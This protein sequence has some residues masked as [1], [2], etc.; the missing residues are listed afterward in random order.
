MK[1]QFIIKAVFFFFILQ[2]YSV[3]IL[4]GQEFQ[5]KVLQETSLERLEFLMDSLNSIHQVQAENG[6]YQEAAESIKGLNNASF[7]WQKLNDS[8]RIAEMTVKYQLDVQ[9]AEIAVEEVQLAN[10]RKMI[11]LGLG[12]GLILIL[13]ILLIRRNIKLKTKREAEKFQLIQLQE[14]TN[15]NLQDEQIR[16]IA[17][18]KERINQ[19]IELKNQQLSFQTLQLIKKNQ[20]LLEIQEKVNNWKDNPEF[21]AEIKTD[22][23]NQIN[24][25]EDW[26]AFLTHYE[27]VYPHFFPKLKEVNQN[28][29]END[30][31]L[32][33]LT[34]L[35]MSAK[36]IA[37][38]L[39]LNPD[40]VKT[41]RYRLSKKLELEKGQKLYDFL[42][43]L[44]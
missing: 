30:F 20:L 42:M 3:S 9:K 14:E 44:G 15:R 27:A 24:P 22:I 4:P 8:L 35:Q 32:S 6:D 11:F 17:N 5:R 41:A 38:L 10:Q 33:V 43:Q 34:R 36:E 16:R 1:K 13:A 25:E 29:T 39:G 7:R 40:S 26:N 28:L 31:K 23:Q 2:I 21:L 18:E 19:E 37:V 12:I